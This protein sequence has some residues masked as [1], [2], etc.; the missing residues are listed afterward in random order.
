MVIYYLIISIQYLIIPMLI[1]ISCTAASVT[2]LL[3]N[4]YFL[5]P[6]LR[7]GEGVLGC[8]PGSEDSGWALSHR[9]EADGGPAGQSP[10]QLGPGLHACPLPRRHFL[11]PAVRP[12]LAGG[13]TFPLFLLYSPTGLKTL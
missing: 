13:A 10:D 4:I 6:P 3:T 7:S 1:G 12:S 8:S 9:E 11:P 5:M 2:H